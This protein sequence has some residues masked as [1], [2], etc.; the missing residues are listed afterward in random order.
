MDSI[1]CPHIEK[2]ALT[3]FFIADAERLD[4]EEDE[5]FNAAYST[6]KSGSVESKW[7][8]SGENSFVNR[9]HYFRDIYDGLS[10]SLINDLVRITGP[11]DIFSKYFVFLQYIPIE[12]REYYHNYFK[13]VLAAFKSEFILYAHEWSGMDDEDNKA[14]DFAEL[15]ESSSWEINSSDSLDTMDKFYYESL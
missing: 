2:E 7:E 9:L 10:V 3:D 6:I 12:I 11:F 5:R 8:L 13:K 4:R 15:K 14:F 1:K